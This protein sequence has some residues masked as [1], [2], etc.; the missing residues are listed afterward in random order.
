[1]T[2]IANRRRSIDFCM[3]SIMTSSI[4][5][6]T[7]ANHS[8]TPIYY[9]QLCSKHV[10]LLEVLFCILWCFIFEE[11]SLPTFAY[12]LKSYLSFK[13]LTNSVLLCACLSLAIFSL[14]FSD[15]LFGTTDVYFCMSFLAFT[16]I[17]TL[18]LYIFISL[19]SEL[20]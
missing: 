8:F 15:P 20:F 11:M 4:S 2:S 6:V 19:K 1:M 3:H 16:S 7:V 5:S 9:L 12:L 14:R 18:F 10:K 13:M 17:I